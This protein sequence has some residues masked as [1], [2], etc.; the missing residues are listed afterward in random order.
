[1][2]SKII[3]RSH[4]LTTSIKIPETNPSIWAID[5][6]VLIHKSG[7]WY[8]N[9]LNTNYTTLRRSLH[10]ERQRCVRYVINQC[11]SCINGIAI[12]LQLP[13]ERHYDEEN[14]IIIFIESQ[15]TRVINAT[16]PQ[17]TNNQ[18][19]QAL[20][21]LGEQLERLGC[22]DWQLGQHTD[23][24]TLYQIPIPACTDEEVNE[25]MKELSDINFTH[26]IKIVPKAIPDTNHNTQPTRPFDWWRYDY[27]YI[28]H[29]GVP[30][31]IK[32]IQAKFHQEPHGVI[33]SRDQEDKYVDVQLRSRKILHRFYP[34]MK[35]TTHSQRGFT[36]MIIDDSIVRSLACQAYLKSLG[37]YTVQ[38][39]EFDMKHAKD[40]YQGH[41]WHIIS[42]NIK[43]PFP[44]WVMHG[45][46]NT[47]QTDQR[48]TCKFKYKYQE[49]LEESSLIMSIKSEQISF[50]RLGHVP[51]GIHDWMGQVCYIRGMRR[52]VDGLRSFLQGVLY[53]VGK[54]NDDIKTLIKKFTEYIK[55]HNNLILPNTSNAY[56]ERLDEYGAPDEH[57]MV[58]WLQEQFNI[59]IECINVHKG[60]VET[61]QYYGDRDVVT[62]YKRLKENRRD[63]YYEPIV[64]RRYEPIIKRGS[65]KFKDTETVHYRKSP[66]RF[67]KVYGKVPIY[68]KITPIVWRPVYEHD[69]VD[70]VPIVSTTIGERRVDT[71][72]CNGIKRIVVCDDHV[73]DDVI[74]HIQYIVECLICIEKLQSDNLFEL[75]NEVSRKSL[76]DV[77]VYNR[78]GQLVVNIKTSCKRGRDG[79]L[80]FMFLSSMH[81]CGL[82]AFNREN[83]EKYGKRI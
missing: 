76:C 77:L 49:K 21:I 54:T 68:K 42:E 78:S 56:L 19:T 7:A 25:V 51:K 23:I 45:T 70:D 36:P 47:Y 20:R 32:G 16:L 60:V 59:A 37:S 39:P 10:K 5:Q 34:Q 27:I 3:V 62:L 22:R 17:R 50:G 43:T 67:T 14:Y 28:F 82:V 6:A 71:C 55:S 46:P 80:C 64:N 29:N 74:K 11:Q 81:V 44:G 72:T 12:A 13:F 30:L 48:N 15:H 4:T 61:C 41:Q 79:E 1:M 31:D 26:K 52:Q 9:R 2:C 73:Y 53:C 33:V 65:C 75:F 8:I 40:K 18:N 63:Y 58:H 24:T 38:I 66:I 57:A 83:V 35:G 69:V